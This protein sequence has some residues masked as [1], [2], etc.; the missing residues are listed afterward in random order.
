MMPRTTNLTRYLAMLIILLMVHGS[1][2][3]SVNSMAYSPDMSTDMSGDKDASVEVTPCPM[4]DKAH[5]VS[6]Q[7]GADNNHGTMSSVDQ[8]EH[9][10]HSA[11]PM[12]EHCCVSTSV[13]AYFVYSSDPLLPQPDAVVVP[14]PALSFLSQEL[15]VELRPPR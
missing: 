1:M 8:S 4:A 5:K 15:L 7:N 14:D 9:G 12:A 3:F 11:C 2:L 13:G 10:N 6:D